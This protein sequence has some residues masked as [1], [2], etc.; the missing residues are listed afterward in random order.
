MHCYYGIYDLAIVKMSAQPGRA[1]DTAGAVRGLGAI[2]PANALRPV[3]TRNPPTSKQPRRPEA[4]TLHGS[5]ARAL[6]GSCLVPA[7]STLHTPASGAA[8]AR[9][10][11]PTPKHSQE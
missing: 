5:A 11:A 8:D 1:T 9:R 4:P 6:P 10:S 2:Y 3:L 7:S